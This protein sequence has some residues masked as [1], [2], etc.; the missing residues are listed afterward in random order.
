MRVNELHMR[1]TRVVWKA[2]ALGRDAERD[3]V[4]CKPG[5]RMGVSAVLQFEVP[6]DL[7]VRVACG[8]AGVDC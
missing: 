5:D 7:A 3:S 1:L 2:V 4:T 6:L 8:V